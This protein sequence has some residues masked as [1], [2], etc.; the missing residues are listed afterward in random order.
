MSCSRVSEMGWAQCN[1]TAS[2]AAGGRLG[3]ALLVYNFDDQLL[4][5]SCDCNRKNT[6]NVES[7]QVKHCA[8]NVLHTMPKQT[9]TTATVR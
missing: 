9:L 2:S 1:V 7:K 3:M 6:V 4:A 5:P 8:D